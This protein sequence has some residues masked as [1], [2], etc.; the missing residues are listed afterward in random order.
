MA[1]AGAASVGN[2]IAGVAPHRAHFVSCGRPPVLV[3]SDSTVAERAAMAPLVDASIPVS[4]YLA[5]RRPGRIARLLGPA[6]ISGLPLH[7]APSRILRAR[8]SAVRGRVDVDLCHGGLPRRGDNPGYTVTLAAHRTGGGSS[9]KLLP[10]LLLG[11]PLGA[12]A[13]GSVVKWRNDAGD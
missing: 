5:L 8:R 10:I 1:R 3:A 12:F 9:M 6:G 2:G 13:G 4:G 11:L 7:S